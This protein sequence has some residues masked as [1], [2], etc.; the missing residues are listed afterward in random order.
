MDDAAAE[1]AYLS[2]YNFYNWDA[3]NATFDAAEVTGLSEVITNADVT[4]NYKEDK[5]IK[6]AGVPYYPVEETTGSAIKNEIVI[7]NAD[8]HLYRHTDK[9][10]GTAK[11][12]FVYKWMDK[13]ADGVYAWEQ[14]LEAVYNKGELV[15]YK[16]LVNGGYLTEEKAVAKY[17]EVESDYEV[18][19]EILDVEDLFE[20]PAYQMSLY[21]DNMDGEWDRAYVTTIYVSAHDTSV[22]NNAY[23]YGP[24]KNDADAKTDGK[25][26]NFPVTWVDV[27]GNAVELA[28]GDVY[29]YTYNEQ[30]NQV[31]V[32]DTYEI[33]YG[34]IERIYTVN[35]KAS[36]NYEVA[37]RING[38][39]YVLGNQY[40]EA[41]GI[42]GFVLANKTAGVNALA[43][44]KGLKNDGNGFNTDKVASINY[45]YDVNFAPET[46]KAKNYVGFVA[47]DGIII[48]MEA[49]SDEANF[50]YALF[51]N[52]EDY[53]TE[54]IYLDLWVNGVVEED[55]AVTR[56]Q[57]ANGK[58][59]DVADLGMKDLMA[60]YQY[61][62]DAKK[63]D[64]YK[65]SE[66]E[67]GVTLS[68]AMGNTPKL[69]TC[70]K[71]GAGACDDIYCV[72]HE[73]TKATTVGSTTTYSIIANAYGLALADIDE[74]L[75]FTDGIGDRGDDNNYVALRTNSNTLFYFVNERDETISIF[76]G[77]PEDGWFINA[78]AT[79][80]ANKLGFNVGDGS[81]AAWNDTSAG[82]GYANS[83]NG[84]ASTVVVYFDDINDIGGF[85]VNGLKSKL[86]YM[87]KAVLSD[88][89]Y[90]GQDGNYFD[91]YEN[92]SGYELGLERQY[93]D[94]EFYLYATKAGIDM[95]TGSAV[96]KFYVHEDDVLEAGKFYWMTNN[97]VIISEAMDAAAAG[98]TPV[99]N[100]KGSLITDDI[101]EFT[102]AV[103]ANK[104]DAVYALSAAKDNGN[105]KTTK[106]AI[107]E[108]TADYTTVYYLETLN[109]NKNVFVAI[110]DTG[111]APTSIVKDAKWEWNGLTGDVT[112]KATGI[113][114]TYT[115][116][117]Y[118]ATSTTNKSTATGGTVELTYFQKFDDD[119]ES[120]T[121]GTFVG[122]GLATTAG[123]NGAFGTKSA[124]KDGVLTID[125]FNF[126]ATG[127]PITLKPGIY[128]AV[129]T[130]N[131]ATQT[132]GVE[133]DGLT[134]EYKFTV[135]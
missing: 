117:D 37:I 23:E 112:V 99:K 76:K 81:K 56:I 93:W 102:T 122:T 26:Y 100:F 74:G 86:V 77:M 132:N 34:T 84:V 28:Q 64:I 133:I 25:K 54:A 79:V 119:M 128:R 73:I 55:V 5:K 125:A 66:N 118:G 39:N 51:E 13:D 52:F 116:Y 62:L 68:L 75:T 101:R 130:I 83:I 17:G 20:V 33:Q 107:N 106:T 15:Y 2:A 114:G 91:P 9:I 44:L 72:N 61:Y 127:T 92:Y 120:D 46:F 53:D 49:I 87:T 59:A 50:K 94:E 69:T 70:T 80:Y 121:Y 22:K 95:K 98:V 21:D 32:L 27:E 123:F 57:K 63:G 109:V 43:N 103:S 129:F 124:L 111:S 24:M 134:I 110:V 104:F 10:L 6:I 71:E 4:V 40:R 29:K 31:T 115:L 42:D 18:S 131:D 105:I 7:F 35:D 97:N 8:E 47:V 126:K 96:S 38:E 12:G 135:E 88:Y 67:T 3:E 58:Y 82:K 11:D 19:L 30:L 78:D 45:T 113:V 60:T 14:V 48:L 85:N 89:Y 65:Y 36:A 108:L 1:A 16:D 41:K 90:F